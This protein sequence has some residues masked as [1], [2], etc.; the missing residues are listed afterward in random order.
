MVCETFIYL[1]RK[2]WQQMQRNHDTGILVREEAITSTNLQEL[3]IA[4]SD[5]I[6]IRDFSVHEESKK[7]GADWEWWFL[8]KDTNE[9]IGFAVQAKRLNSGSYD[10]GYEPENNPPQIETL[11]NYCADVGDITPLYCWYNYFPQW[12]ELRD[13]WG[14]ALADGYYVYSRHV[15][16]QYSL[17]DLIPNSIPWHQLVCGFDRSGVTHIYKVASAMAM[18]ASVPAVALPGK[19]QISPEIHTTGLP[20]RVLDMLSTKGKGKSLIQKDPPVPYPGGLIIIERRRPKSDRF[21]SF[22]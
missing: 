2:T 7:T 17:K 8:D 12:E 13:E 14:C 20:Q 16:K 19:V 1:A 5:R 10:V 3:K 6:K 18:H 22:E 9:A 4:H 15:K 11:L 21:E